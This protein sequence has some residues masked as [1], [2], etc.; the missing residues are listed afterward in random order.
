M[1]SFPAVAD[2][3]TTSVP[4]LSCTFDGCTTDAKWTANIKNKYIILGFHFHSI[5]RSFCCDLEWLPII[6]AGHYGNSQ[7]QQRCNLINSHGCSWSTRRLGGVLANV[8][9]G[10]LQFAI[11]V[12]ASKVRLGFGE[13]SCRIGFPIPLD[14]L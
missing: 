3:S 6:G 5:I 8:A 12:L 2:E 1:A 10:K 13:L 4:L 11:P 9:E 7:D 14:L